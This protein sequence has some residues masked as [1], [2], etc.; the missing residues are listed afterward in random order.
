MDSV[1]VKIVI[2]WVGGVIEIIEVKGVLIGKVVFY[3][4]YFLNLNLRR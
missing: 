3:S 4:L 2:N 1:R